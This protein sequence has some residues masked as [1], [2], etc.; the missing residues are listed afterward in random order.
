MLRGDGGRPA[1]PSAVSRTSPSRRVLTRPKPSD[2][3]VRI[4]TPRLSPLAYACSGLGRGIGERPAHLGAEVPLD[5]SV[6]LEPALEQLRV[7]GL[8]LRTCCSS[9]ESIGLPGVRVI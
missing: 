4:R 9:P 5:V 6:L 1:L 3:P 2:G 8:E 7:D